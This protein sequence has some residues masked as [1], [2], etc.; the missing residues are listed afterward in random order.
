MLVSG[1]VAGFTAVH[2]RAATSRAHV[3][4][5]PVASSHVTQRQTPFSE[6]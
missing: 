3:W 5:W 6:S 4:C 2:F 1:S